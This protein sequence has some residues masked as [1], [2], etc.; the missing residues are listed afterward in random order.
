MIQII[1]GIINLKRQ[2]IIFTYQKNNFIKEKYNL[3]KQIE[4][5]NLLTF[6]IKK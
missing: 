1:G 5:N 6:E 2:N 4:K 3:T